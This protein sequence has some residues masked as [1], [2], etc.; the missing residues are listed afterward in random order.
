[1]KFNFNTFMN[2]FSQVAMGA[3]QTYEAK[4]GDNKSL[5]QVDYINMIIPAVFAVISAIETTDTPTVYPA[6]LANTPTGNPPVIT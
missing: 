5:H 6:P 1:M 4:Q 3:A 2:N